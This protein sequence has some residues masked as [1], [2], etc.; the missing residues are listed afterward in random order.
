MKKSF[1]LLLMLLG[2]VVVSCNPLDD[3]HDEIDNEL[4]NQLAVA[5]ADYV[6]T[7]DDYDDLGLNF[8]NFSSEE[9]A[10]TLIPTLLS[11]L[12]PTYGAGSILNVGFDLYNPLRIESYTVASSDYALIDLS[13]DYFTGRGEVIDFLDEK[14]PQ[15]QEGEYIELT[16]NILAEEIAYTLTADDFDVIGDE[17]GDVYPEPASS[18]A[19]YSNFDRRDDR[20]AY[21]SN[22]MIV[23]ALGAVISEEFG[24]VAGQKYNVSYAI[25]D[26]S[27]GTESMTVQFDGNA[28]VAVGGMAYDFSDADYD[29]VGAEFADTYPGPAAN[30]AR[31]GSFDVRSTSDNYWSEGMLL[32]AIN[33]TLKT[34]YPD[35]ADGSKFVVSYAIYNGSV[36]SA[37]TNVILSGDDY[38]IDADASVSTIEETTVFAYTNG[39][40]DE[41]YMLPENSYTEEFGQRFGNFGDEEEA[42]AKIGIFLGRE[43]PYAVEGEYKAV[44]Y[45]FYN[46]EATVTEY[47]NYVFQNGAWMAI[48]SVTSE[49]LQFGYENGMWVPDNTI[50][51][52]LAGPDYGIIAEALSGNADLS[53]QIASMERY[54]NFDRRPGAS[55]YWSD[56]SIL[57]AMQAFLNETA[58]NAAEGQKYVITFDIYNGSNTTEDIRL[59]K[60][61]GEWVRF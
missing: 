41:P 52:T 61:G 49:T 34:A 56:D 51:Y 57:L 8:P 16:Y 38:V 39:D 6:L 27:S 1:N 42:L 35:A 5:Q 37:I 36:S 13:T 53:T 25:Y 15:V 2:L 28:Y 17:L 14:Y 24:D 11:D 4:D 58:P 30:V 47:V 60:E 12:F 31:F 50:K 54:T 33:F 26:G 43:F 59:I 20:D 7:E 48:P 29:A 44:G 19:Q 55:A 3:I 10:R 46:G 32:E 40:W 45:K 22:D 18:A 21:W 9:D 23:E